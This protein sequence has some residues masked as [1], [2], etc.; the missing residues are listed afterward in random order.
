MND[1]PFEILGLDSGATDEAIRNRYLELVR[2]HTPE[3]DPQRFT[4][5]REAYERLRD[6]KTRLE[7]R[8]FDAGNRET[9]DHLIEEWACRKP[10][11][12][13]S[14]KV[15]LQATRTS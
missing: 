4:A 9:L 7:H 5:V 8:L 1:D 13:L 6:W 10:R 14:L 2:R 11:R 15:L 12:R 3:R